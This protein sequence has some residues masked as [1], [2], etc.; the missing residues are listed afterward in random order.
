[1]VRDRGRTEK[2][3]KLVLLLTIKIDLEGFGILHRAEM[4]FAVGGHEVVVVVGDIA[5]DV[6]RPTIVGTPRKVSLIVQKIGAVFAID[7]CRTEEVTRGLVAHGGHEAD[8]LIA[9]PYV[10]SRPEDAHIGRTLQGFGPLVRNVEHGRHTVAI[11]RLETARREADALNHIGIDDT[12]TLLRA[13]ADKQR[14]I[15][16]NAIEIDAIL[17][18]R[19]AAHIVLRGKFVVRADTSLRGDD[20]L[21]AIARC[22]G[23]EVSIGGL[24]ALG[25]SRLNVLT[26]HDCLAHS[27]P[28][29]RQGD[30]QAHGVARRTKQA[31]ARLV[32]NHG[33]DD[34]HAVRRLAVQAV[35]ALEIRE[36][37]HVLALYLHGGKFD[38][39]PVLINNLAKHTGARLAVRQQGQQEEDICQKKTFQ[40]RYRL[41]EKEISGH[42]RGERGVRT[43]V[44]GFS[45][46]RIQNGWWP[47]H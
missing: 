20:F 11:A 8:L 41:L 17:V 16:L 45:H 31:A 42:F 34:G 2:G 44:L 10:G 12:Q 36:G 46:R 3:A 24:D 1:M 18:E 5:D 19:T 22:G 29:R 47:S 35:L 28:Q 38:G 6:K 40:G 27:C 13:R 21:H 23:H 25:R 37:E 26:R 39:L 15:D 9:P 14:T 33:I 43:S 4:R 7:I 30:V 32:T